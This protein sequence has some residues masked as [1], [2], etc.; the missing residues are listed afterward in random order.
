MN[1][2]LLILSIYLLIN[3]AL[4]GH[5]NNM[6]EGTNYVPPSFKGSL[7]FNHNE[8]EE[9]NTAWQ[10]YLQKHPS[11]DVTLHVEFEANQTSIYYLNSIIYFSEQNCSIWLN[12]K[13]YSNSDEGQN[14][15]PGLK[16][17][18][19]TAHK[20]KFSLNSKQIKNFLPNFKDYLL[21]TAEGNYYS[22]DYAITI[23]SDLTKAEF[24][25]L[26]NQSMIIDNMEIVAG[27][28]VGM[29]ERQ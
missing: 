19:I 28:V 29:G 16:L 2:K 14:I 9:L 12:N 7:M 15:L 11:K 17:E 13:R 5:A 18:K 1:R 6:V 3:F 27:H 21:Q 22:E 8:L 23:G 26:P 20:V 10:K 24:T 4:S 25:L